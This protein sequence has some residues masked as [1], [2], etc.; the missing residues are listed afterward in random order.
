[1]AALSSSSSAHR[2]VGVEDVA[3]H[4]QP[5][6]GRHSHTIRDTRCSFTVCSAADTV[7]FIY[8]TQPTSTASGKTEQLKSRNGCASSHRCTSIRCTTVQ[9]QSTAMRCSAPLTAL[10]RAPGWSLGRGKEGENLGEMGREERARGKEGKGRGE[11]ERRMEQREGRAGRKRG[12][13]CEC[14]VRFLGE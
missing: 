5:P 1:M 3:S 4:S 13:V 11:E 14:S 9:L 12:K 6:I 10:P 8:C 2:L 7:S